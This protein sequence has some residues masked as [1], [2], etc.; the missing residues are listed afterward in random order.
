MDGESTIK[1]GIRHPVGERRSG[2]GCRGDTQIPGEGFVLRV[3]G[4]VE[5]P[6]GEPVVRVRTFSGI[7]G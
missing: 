1:L 6:V 4:G 7:F 3:W 2:S 5:V